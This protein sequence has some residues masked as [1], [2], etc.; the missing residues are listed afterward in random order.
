MSAIAVLDKVSYIYPNAKESELARHI[1]IVFEDHEVQTT[2]T[3][4]ANAI[5]FALENHRSSLYDR[6]YFL[7][8]PTEIANCF[9]NKQNTIG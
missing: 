3:S 2:D 8:T 9:A 6:K 4:A 5:A 7:I 1:G